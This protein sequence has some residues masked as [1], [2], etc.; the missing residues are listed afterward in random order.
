PGLGEPIDV[1]EHQ[2]EPDRALVL[3]EPPREV[4]KRLGE[5]AAK[6]RELTLVRCEVDLDAKHIDGLHRLSEEI[7]DIVEPL[8][9]L[10]LMQDCLEDSPYHLLHGV[11]AA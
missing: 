11:G 10:A 6:R 1:I 5:I 8:L 7:L 4:Q 2:R 3:L 9:L